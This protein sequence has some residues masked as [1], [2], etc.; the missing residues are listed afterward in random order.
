MIP[1]PEDEY[2]H[3]LNECKNNLHARVIWPKGATPLTV[4][5]LREKLKSIW[6]SL[7]RWGVS[8][9]G[10]GYYEFCFSS[11]E[12]A[13]SV[14]S[15]GT[16]NLNPGLLKLFAW[17]KEFSSSTQKNTSAQV[18]LR[19]HGL[20][21]EYWRPKILF[22]IASSVGSPICIDENTGKNRMDRSFAHFARVQVDV[23]LATELKQRVLVERQG[24]AMYVD[25]EYENLPDFCSYCK[26]VGHH[27]NHCRR[28]AHIADEE[29]RREKI[30]KN[31]APVVEKN[32]QV[33]ATEI[34]DLDKVDLKVPENDSNTRK[35]VSIEEDNANLNV[36]DIEGNKTQ[37]E[38]E[39]FGK[40]NSDSVNS[41]E[42]VCADSDDINSH[43]SEFVD[44]TQLD[45]E[46]AKS[47]THSPS[48]LTPT[49][50]RIQKDMHFLRTSW[51]NLAD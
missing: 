46:E 27:V 28:R 49:P 17:T 24:F 31:K 6:K 15:V 20:A 42:E 3:G 9:L 33:E 32:K 41:E 19:M 40:N 1:I 16:W 22:A 25:F 38:K 47:T 2:Q 13:R 18:W 30:T 21:Q 14:R 7:G 23:D 37:Q 45:E 8:S 10:K 26:V 51:A 4:Y 48:K 35:G 29:N 34:V 12:D 39:N 36:A 5:A 43:N 50:D 11:I 44:A